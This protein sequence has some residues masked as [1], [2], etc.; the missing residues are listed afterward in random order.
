MS[1]SNTGDTS[2]W[3]GLVHGLTQIETD[4]HFFLL[5]NAKV[6]EKI[7]I[8]SNFEWVK[9]GSTRNRLWSLL[10]FPKL[11]SRVGANVAHTQYNISPLM[12][13]PSITTIH[14]VSFFIGPEWFP[15]LDR[16]ILQHQILGTC[17][18]AKKILTVSQTSKS[19]IEQ[20]IPGSRGKV[21]VTYNALGTNIQPMP[22]KD[23]QSII[24]KLN[25]PSVYALTVG[26]RWPRKNMNLAIEACERSNIP[27]VVTGKSGWGET[28]SGAI[29]TGYVSD[30]T[31]TAL[32]QCASLYL[33]P[34]FH[35]G[36]GIP[37]LEAFACECPVICSRGGALPEV[38]G[39]AA[40]IQE[41]FNP[42]DWARSIRDALADSGKLNRLKAL[43]MERLKNFS[44]TETARK[45]LE[46]YR[47]VGA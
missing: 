36:F 8:P 15:V 5:T 30:Q 42:E 45:T 3:R 25:L 12:R 22:L 9:G 24:S 16:K 44:W 31:L 34:S 29:S 26:T 43:G 27:C 21:E 39:Q 6:D 11:A 13:V 41:S 10:S 23:A 38:A 33:A 35:E 28:K 32:Y 17:R 47:E 14:D 37:L 40:I 7:P 20:Y 2:Y 1:S 19:E 4:A 46:I 18:R